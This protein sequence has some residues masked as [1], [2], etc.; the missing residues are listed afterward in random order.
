MNSSA[1]RLDAIEKAIAYTFAD[2]GLLTEALTH[3]SF[4]A[5]HSGH[6]SYERLEFL[7]DA[8]LELATTDMIYDRFPVAPE[9]DMTRIR[10]SVVDETTLASVARCLDLPGAMRLGRGEDRSGGRA[11]DSMLSDVTEALLGAVYLDGGWIAAHGV[12]FR[13][14]GPL[15]EAVVDPDGAKDARSRLQELL[16]STGATVSFDYERTGPDH[17][18]RFTATATI[19]G[20]KIATG[21][22]ASKKAAAIDAARATLLIVDE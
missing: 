4:V 14:W 11:R 20:E 12:I 21:S 8:V 9:G 6:A 10:A 5:E 16:A 22:G 17:A 15:L 3:A 7:G 13:L 2:R 1:A 19:E 18:A